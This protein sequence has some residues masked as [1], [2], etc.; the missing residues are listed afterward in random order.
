MCAIRVSQVVGQLKVELQV[1]GHAHPLRVCAQGTE[2]PGIQV[3]LRGNQAQGRQQGAEQPREQ[4]VALPGTLREAGI[5]K[6]ERDATQ[7]TGAKQGRPDL[8]LH[9][10][11]Q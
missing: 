7:V 9:N 6:R 1:A 2:T 5:D 10:Q 11:R 4:A 3:A 8:V